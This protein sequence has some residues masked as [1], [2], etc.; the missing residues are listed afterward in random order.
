[1]SKSIGNSILMSD[2]LDEI[3]KKIMTAYTD[4]KKIRKSD[5][6]NPDGCVAFAYHKK[7]HPDDIDQIDTDCRAGKL[8]C[9]DHKRQTARIIGDYFAPIREKRAYYESHRSEV[10]DIIADGDSRA[11]K[12]ALATMADVQEA[13]GLG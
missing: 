12:V 10:E 3:E 2:P 13:M 7:F 9:V 8:G 4:P 6:G 5:P 1:M 11:R